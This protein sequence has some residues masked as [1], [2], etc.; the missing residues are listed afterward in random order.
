MIFPTLFCSIKQSVAGGE[1]VNHVHL[2]IMV[3]VTNNAKDMQ[4]VWMQL[5]RQAATVGDLCHIVAMIVPYA[6]TS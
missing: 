3:D 5:D 4:C 2:A 1:E 6:N